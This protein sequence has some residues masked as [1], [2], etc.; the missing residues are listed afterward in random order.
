MEML[1][2]LDSTF[3]YLE[4]EH[5]P[6]AIGG[7]YVIDAIDAPGSFSYDSWSSLVESRLKL[8]K[9]FRERLVEVPCDLSFPYWIRDPGF[10]LETHLPKV[11]LPKPAGMAELMQMAA[12]TWG[13]VLDREQ[14]LW[15]HPP[16]P[17]GGRLGIGDGQRF[18]PVCRWLRIRSG[19]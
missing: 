14:P 16:L 7:I 10:D 12:T 1:S 5:S 15:Q 4:S 19:S 8:S 18:H 13:R 2:A 6:M 17:Q 11:T 3:I 9:V